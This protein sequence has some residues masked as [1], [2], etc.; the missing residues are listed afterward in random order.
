MQDEKYRKQ[1][2]TSARTSRCAKRRVT[3]AH[4][5]SAKMF[6]ISRLTCSIIT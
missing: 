5:S 1:D 2:E 3:Y 6:R 4:L